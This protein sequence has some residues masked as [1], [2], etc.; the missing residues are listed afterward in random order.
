MADRLTSEIVTGEVDLARRLT[1][2]EDERAIERLKYAY[3]SALDGGYELDRICSMFV[4][5]GR[6]TADGF[7]DYRGH[8]EIRAFF[9]DLSRSIA[10]AHHYASGPHIEVAADGRSAAAEWKLLCLSG[11]RHRDD[12]SL[13]LPIVELGRYRDRLVKR[14]GVWLFEELRVDVT[15]SKRVLDLLDRPA[16]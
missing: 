9:A 16:A 14:D 5:D 3:T 11:Q 10:Y 8:D 2:L 15:L 6:W 12:P 1:L 13:H 7:G 4:P